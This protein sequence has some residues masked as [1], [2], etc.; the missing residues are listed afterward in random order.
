MGLFSIRLDPSDFYNNFVPDVHESTAVKSHADEDIHVFSEG[1]Q[2]IGLNVCL[3]LSFHLTKLYASLPVQ[4]VESS[5]Q[6]NRHD[7]QSRQ[8]N[9]RVVRYFTLNFRNDL[10]DKNPRMEPDSTETDCDR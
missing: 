8:Y 2:F 9:L 7:V 5:N 1:E 3:C 10:S 6:W 4:C